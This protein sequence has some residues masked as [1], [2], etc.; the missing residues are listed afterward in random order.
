MKLVCQRQKKN[1]SSYNDFCWNKNQKIED[2]QFK[3]VRFVK[4][5]EK[6]ENQYHEK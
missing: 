1:E 3:E 5:Q 2:T 6:Y 4:N